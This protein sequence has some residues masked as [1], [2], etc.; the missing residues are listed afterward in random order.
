MVILDR[1]NGNC[2]T[3]DDPSG[4]ICV[5]NKTEDVNLNVFSTMTRINE[6][7]K[8]TK[9]ISCGFKCKFGGRKCNSIQQ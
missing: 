2:N 9:H 3:L 6:G 7:N 5:L 8:L 1:C 4:K